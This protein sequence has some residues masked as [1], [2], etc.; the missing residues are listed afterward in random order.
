MIN[1]L[2]AMFNEIYAG[3]RHPEKSGCHYNQISTLTEFTLAPALPP[4][5]II[6][7]HLFRI[8]FYLHCL[9]QLGR[10]P[11]RPRPLTENIELETTRTVDVYQMN[12][13]VTVTSNEL[14]DDS[15]ILRRLDKTV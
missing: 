12:R 7:S 8:A 3:T 15:I 13:R 4:P 6:I 5:L 9:V 14:H 10:K 11:S 2:I 1:M